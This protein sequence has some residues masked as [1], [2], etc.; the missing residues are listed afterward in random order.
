MVACPSKPTGCVSAR[1]LEGLVLQSKEKKEGRSGPG[2]GIA[3]TLELSMAFQ[4]RTTKN[5]AVE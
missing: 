1:V 3:K 5:G 2:V 4:N